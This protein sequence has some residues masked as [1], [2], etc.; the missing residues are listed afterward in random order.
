MPTI[1]NPIKI[2]TP[3]QTPALT[4]GVPGAS[5]VVVGEPNDYFHVWTTGLNYLDSDVSL[6][7]SH[8]TV[9]WQIE[10][11]GKGTLHLVPRNGKFKTGEIKGSAIARIKL[12]QCHDGFG[13]AAMTTEGVLSLLFAHH[14]PFARS[15]ETLAQLLNFWSIDMAMNSWLAYHQGINHLRIK[16]D[17]S[18]YSKAL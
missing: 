6:H 2:P 4:P 16:G 18:I 5:F 8:Y 10:T 11:K 15:R 7:R 12:K 14:L 3:P 9:V 13:H 17:L 1:L